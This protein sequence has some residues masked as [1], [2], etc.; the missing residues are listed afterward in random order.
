MRIQRFQN[1]QL[2]DEI[3][4]AGVSLR[5]F[6]GD[7]VSRNDLINALPGEESAILE[8]VNLDDEIRKFCTPRWTW[9]TMCG[10]EGF[11]VMRDG[12]VHFWIMIRMN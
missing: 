12:K 8:M 10:L 2:P 1:P 5:D 6:L 11:A 3:P 7:C 4:I 9:A